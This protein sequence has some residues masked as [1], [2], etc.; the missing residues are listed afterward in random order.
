[1]LKKVCG[2]RLLFAMMVSVLVLA[3]CRA[4]G[5]AAD[6]LFQ[7]YKGSFVGDASAVSNMAY[8]IAGG[9]RIQG[10]A[11]HTEEP[12]YGITMYLDGAMS[13]R[14]CQEIT[15][16][17]AAFL[18]ALVQNADWVRFELDD[19]HSTV[20]REQFTALVGKDVTTF[21]NEAELLAFIREYLR[22]GQ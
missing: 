8:A 7:R 2:E 19:R 14:E 10:F 15:V 13:E 21:N 9:D 4:E 16:H 3:G 11:L 18:F 22:S 20:A 5:D 1:M 6:D 12:P 17:Q